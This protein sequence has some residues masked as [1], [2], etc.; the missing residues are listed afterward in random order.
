MNLAFLASP[1]LLSSVPLNS[2]GPQITL[3]AAVLSWPTMSYDEQD[4]TAE[5]IEDYQS[6]LDGLTMNSRFEITNLTQIARDLTN[7]AFP[8]AETLEQHIKKVG[9]PQP[10]KLR[11]F[12]PSKLASSALRRP[13]VLPPNLLHARVADTKTG[14]SAEEAP[15]HVRP[16]LD[17]Q[18]HW[19]PL[20]FI[21]WQ[22]SV[23][24]I[25]GLVRLGQRQHPQEDGGNVEDLEGAS[26][27]VHRQ[28]P[29]LPARRGSSDRECLD[30]GQDFGPTSPPGAN[31]DPAPALRQ[32]RTTGCTPP[33]HANPSQCSPA[34]QSA[35]TTS[36]RNQRPPTRISPWPAGIPSATSKNAL[37][38]VL[39]CFG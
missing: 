34:V 9:A 22:E 13:D 36:C 26:P 38:R 5:V 28:E 8:I 10:R 15:S 24:D 19:H 16:G 30:Q 11:R 23:L 4:Q 18:E 35:T 27:W 6:A 2:C 29:R 7:Y 14:A 39:S 33:Q 12:C 1:P 31:A 21:L 20:H 17:C 25:H 37:A 3:V 32:R